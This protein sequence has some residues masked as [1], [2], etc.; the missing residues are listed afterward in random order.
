M[1]HAVRIACPAAPPLAPLGTAWQRVRRR[2]PHGRIIDFDGCSAAPRVAGEPAMSADHAALRA[3]ALAAFDELVDLPPAERAKRV[4]QLRRESAPLA[5]EVQRLLDADAPARG[6]AIE[7]GLAALASTV[8]AAGIAPAVPATAGDRIGGFTLLRRIGEGGMGEVWL[9]E[10]DAD[11]FR[12]QV[13]LKRLLRG[14]GSA[15]LRARF[16][17]ER[18]ILAGLSHPGIARFIDGGVGADG[19]PWYAMEYVDGE[20]ITRHAAAAR[21]PVRA[22]V[23]LVASVADAVAHAQARLVVHRDLKPSNILVDR[24]GGVRLLDFGIAKLLEPDATDAE[25]TATGLRAMSPAYA[26]PEQV[27]GGTISTATDVYALGMVLYELLTGSLP[28]AREGVGLERLA[29]QVRSEVTERPSARLARG[30]ADLAIRS[31]DARL[32]RGDLDAVVM[33]A[34]RAEPERRYAGAA[35]FADDLRRWLDGRPVRAQSDSALYRLRRFAGRNRVAVGAALV[36][37]LALGAGTAVSAWQAGIAR[38]EAARAEA[39]AA[40]AERIKGFF[41]ALFR[42]SGPGQQQRGA[43]LTAR[44][45][46]LA[47]A[48]R[49]ERELADAPDAQ[50]EIR[51]ALGAALM[52]FDAIDEARPLLEAAAAWL[53]AHEAPPKRVLVDVLRNLANVHRRKGEFAAAEARIAQALALNADDPDP[54]LQLRTRLQINTTRLVLANERSD[55]EAALAIG[56]QQV[57]DR[58]A[59]YGRD[60]PRVAVDWNN[61]GQTLLLLERPV[62][63]EQAL[64]RALA[65]VD[66]DPAAPEARRAQVMTGIARV[67]LDQGQLGD[68]EATARESLAIALRA[69]GPRH[70]TTVRCSNNVGQAL[71]L[72]GRHAEV[73]ATFAPFL[74]LPP[75]L[76]TQ[77]LRLARLHSGRARLALGDVDGALADLRIAREELVPVG[78][79]TPVTQLQVDLAWAQALARAGRIAEALPVAEAT[80]AKLDAVATARSFRHADAALMGAEVLAAGGRVEDARARRDAALA[81]WRGYWTASA[82]AVPEGLFRL[83]P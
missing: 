67:Q 24:E 20:P 66:A 50:A 80:L 34:L 82:A 23:A 37:A 62:E 57:P 60:D 49:V 64:R 41:A 43:Q 3:Q 68:A 29:E 21:L 15:D 77:G 46:L 26:A 69:A 13:A 36:V 61:L 12:Q 1:R 56:R 2:A 71:L 11:G 52:E 70:L 59:L 17:R 79:S 40:R 10:R 28:H 27:L 63:A 76:D 32:L 42:G 22:R 6:D 45:W 58:E 47:G 72:A 38:A 33:M 31:D 51:A 81:E 54:Q 39:A 14:V 74:D 53:E 48:T 55:Y 73:I 78:L 25:A 30:R 9:A 4:A 18:R 83:P 7:P 8:V 16:E 65:L 35:A 75:A 44:E 5:D 19:T